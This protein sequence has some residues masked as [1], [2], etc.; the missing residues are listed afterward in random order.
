MMSD[1]KLSFDTLS[2][3]CNSG[4]VNFVRSVIIK[5]GSIINQEVL[6]KVFQYDAVANNEMATVLLDYVTDI[7]YSNNN[8]Y[9]N[10]SFLNSACEHGSAT[11]VQWILDRGAIWCE[12]LKSQYSSNYDALSFAVRGGRLDVIKLLMNDSNHGPV[13]SNCIKYALKNAS[14]AGHIDI[15][16]YLISYGV[17]SSALGAALCDAVISGKIPTIEFL[18]NNNANINYYD[19]DHNTPLYYACDN[20]KYDLVRFLLAHGADPNLVDYSRNSPFFTSLWCPD[21]AK[22]LIDSGAN[23]NQMYNNDYK[24]ALLAMAELR[25]EAYYDSFKQLLEHGADPNLAHP[26]T[27]DTALLM[28]A[29]YPSMRVFKLLLEHGADVTHTN[30]AGVSALDLLTGATTDTGNDN[31][32]TELI[33]Q[34]CYEY[35]DRNMQYIQHILK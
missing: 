10:Q 23:V 17:D 20:E 34:L 3:A 1:N 12:S 27:G 26:D 9:K 31:R 19:K 2:N 13:S 21:L 18:L 16:Q 6:L 15:I 11:L 28:C 33:I 22:I 25:T 5:H 35:K 29:R 7:N 8:Y 30:Y 4:D 24:T 14:Y 32:Y